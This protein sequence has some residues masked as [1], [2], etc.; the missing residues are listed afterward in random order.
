MTRSWQPI[1]RTLH[2]GIAMQGNP[3]GP[4]EAWER[5]SVADLDGYFFEIRF[6]DV[7]ADLSTL[8]E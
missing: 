6:R 4:D 2:E 5:G 1:A 8:F 7:L 3:H